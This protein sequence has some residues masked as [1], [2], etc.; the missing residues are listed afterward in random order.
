KPDFQRPAPPAAAAEEG[1]PMAFHPRERRGQGPARRDVL[2]AGMYTALGATAAGP[3]LAAWGGGDSGGA[4]SAAGLELSRPD[5]PVRLPLHPDI[6]AI[7][8][9]LKP[10][11]GTLK[12]LNSPD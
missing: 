12:V 3:L 4:S 10:E 6:P 9:G 5:H 8:N 2:R 1:A 7:G 11:S